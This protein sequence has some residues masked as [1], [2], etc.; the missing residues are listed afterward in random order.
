MGHSSILWQQRD[1]RQTL[2]LGL[3]STISPQRWPV[4]SQRQE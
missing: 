1:F 2:V 4:A 3:R